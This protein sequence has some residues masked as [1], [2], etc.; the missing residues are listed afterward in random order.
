MTMI[1]HLFEKMPDNWLIENPTDGSLLVLIPEGEFLAGSLFA[2]MSTGD[3]NDD[4]GKGEPFPV[5][6]P[7]FY[8]A[9]H[10]VTNAQYKLFV[11]ATGHRPPDKS[12]T[13]WTPVWSGKS[14]PPEKANHPVVCV[15]WDDAEAYCR[16]AGL[17]LPSELE[18][19]K[20]ARGADGRHFPWG[21]EWGNEWENCRHGA[22]KRNETTCGIWQYANGCCVYGIYQMTG[23]AFEWCNDY[24]SKEAYEKYKIGILHLSSKGTDRVVRGGS[25]NQPP[26]VKWLSARYRSKVRFNLRSGEIGF[27]CSRDI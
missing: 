17:R 4:L 13:F 24:Y 14:F 18:W 9:L 15:S 3:T 5:T 8:M 11:D 2:E 6:L 23:N 21:N 1:E 22:N 20:A 12:D 26:F 16:W 19:E 10:P 27:R 7:A 25:F